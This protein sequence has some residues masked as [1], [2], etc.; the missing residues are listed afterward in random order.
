MKAK[1]K[2]EDVKVCKEENA[3]EV[4]TLTTVPSDAIAGQDQSAVSPSHALPPYDS[5]FKPVCGYFASSPTTIPF[6]RDKGVGARKIHYLVGV[7]AHP[8]P[9][10]G[11]EKKLLP[12]Q[13]N[14]G[15]PMITQGA[16][17]G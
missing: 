12:L 15:A 17:M 1:A 16:A 5:R 11:N 2:G 13:G 6:E 7:A 3:C 10:P 4:I 9:P 14:R 8:M